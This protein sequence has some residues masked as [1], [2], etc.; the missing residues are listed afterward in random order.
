MDLYMIGILGLILSF[1]TAVLTFIG[2]FKE[3]LKNL[4]GKLYDCIIRYI[5]KK[6]DRRDDDLED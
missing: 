2:V 4:C 1:I 5:E 6:K 3:E